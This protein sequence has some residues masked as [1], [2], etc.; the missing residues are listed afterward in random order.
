M[1]FLMSQ[2]LDPDQQSC[3]LTLSLMKMEKPRT[4]TGSAANQP[5]TPPAAIATWECRQ[6]NYPFWEYPRQTAWSGTAITRNIASYENRYSCNIF[7]L[8]Q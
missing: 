7:L 6:R 5:N 1:D 4:K 3:N 8:I 2:T